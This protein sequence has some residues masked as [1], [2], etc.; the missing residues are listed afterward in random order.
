MEEGVYVSPNKDMQAAS[1]LVTHFGR[2]VLC[3]IDTE[4]HLNAYP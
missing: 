3:R 2:E 1:M 4:F